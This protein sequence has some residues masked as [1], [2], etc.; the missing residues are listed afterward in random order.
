MEHLG[1][2]GEGTAS[3]NRHYG[4]GTDTFLSMAAIYQGKQIAHK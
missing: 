3:M 4:V 2:M 1:Y